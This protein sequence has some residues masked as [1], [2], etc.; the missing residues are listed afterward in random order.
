MSSS[1]EP[2]QQLKS[3]ADISHDDLEAVLKS[4]IENGSV[5]AEVVNAQLDEIRTTTHDILQDVSEIGLS[6]EQI[7][8]L[9]TLAKQYITMRATLRRYE[10]SIEDMPTWKLIRKSLTPEVLGSALKL[11]EPT[12]LLVSPTTRESK[13][14]AINKHP[15][16][17]QKYA[18][19]FKLEDND[20]WNS[21][22]YKTEN[23]WRVSIVE[24]V[25]D[26]QPD[27]EINDGKKTNFQM[28]KEWLKKLE[29]QGLDTINDADAYLTLVMKGLAEGKPVDN[30]SFTILNAK[31][32]TESSLVAGGDWSSARGCLDTDYPANVR[33]NLRLR[34]MV[35]VDVPQVTTEKILNPEVAETLLGTLKA[36]FK[37][38]KNLHEKI[39]W[40][41]VRIALLS[42]PEKLWSL[43]QLETT[44]GEPDVIGEE[45]D[46][47]I[48]GDCSKESPP[49][50]INVV[51]DR[52]AE[53]YL[54]KRYRK[55]KLNGNAVDMV[56]KYGA[57]LMDKD[58]YEYLYAR[59]IIDS[60]SWS[61]LKTPEDIRKNSFAFSGNCLDGFADVKK[62]L[63]YNHTEKGAFRCVLRVPK[64]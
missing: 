34:G 46:E 51:Y 53:D 61:W 3:L 29:A 56:A 5:S 54:R 24:G 42:H 19:P 6:V 9:V 50:R 11:Q 57:D 25:Q 22:K 21:G 32:L 33:S 26:I 7:E 62:V 30:G 16:E 48:F 15:V 45:K 63:V 2:K 18:Y 35:E 59:H 4:L 13:F 49:G 12:L 41:D 52:E 47:Y 55:Q 43:Q 27:P 20:L 37:K 17:S 40:A 39:R 8:L 36:R 64:T 58:Q 1:G 44:G 10:I 31:N 60:H 14:E 28:A 23:K 38:N